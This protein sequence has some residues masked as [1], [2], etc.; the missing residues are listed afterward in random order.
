[1]DPYS[2]LGVDLSVSD[3]ELVRAFR[4]LA[5]IHHPDRNGGSAES[6]A[7]F[8][9]IITAYDTLRAR[10]GRATEHPGTHSRELEPEAVAR[11]RRRLEILEAAIRSACSDPS[12]SKIAEVIDAVRWARLDVDT[13]LA[14]KG[15]VADLFDE[16]WA[17]MTFT[18]RAKA[19]WVLRQFIGA[20]IARLD[21][22]GMR[23]LRARLTGVL[24]IARGL[25]ESP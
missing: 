2:V 14:M 18:T 4:R 12:P 19:F 11:V 13:A 3:A 25:A 6:V 15:H 17:R 1:M 10:R 21:L 22:V 7:R 16:H 23:N 24:A 8:R 9:E 20:P 5:L